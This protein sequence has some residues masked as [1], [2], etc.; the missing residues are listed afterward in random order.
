[1]RLQSITFKSFPPFKDVTLTLGVPEK[2]EQEGE[3]HILTGANGSGKTRLLS[4]IAAALGNPTELDRRQK[5]HKGCSIKATYG[6]MPGVWPGSPGYYSQWGRDGYGHGLARIPD[7]TTRTGFR[8]ILGIAWKGSAQ[9]KGAD[10]T[11][12]API[13]LK[14]IE[15]QLTF[16]RPEGEDGLICQSMTNLKMSAAMEMMSQPNVSGRAMTMT[17]NLEAAVSKVT[18]RAFSFSV[19]AHPKVSLQVSWGGVAMQFQQLPD[20]LRSIIGF[21]VACVAKVDAFA[22]EH[23]K[24]LDEPLFLL[25]DEPEGHLHPSWQRKILPAAQALFPKAMIFAATHSPFIISSVN[26]GWIYIFRSDDK[27]LVTVENPRPCSKGD[28]YLDVVED[29]LGVTEWYDPETEELL[30]DFRRMR[31]SVLG[32]HWDQEPAL[33]NKSHE[34][35][36][37]S[38]ALEDMMAREM[39]RWKGQGPAQKTAA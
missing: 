30:A 1:M 8:Y 37:R 2:P 14:S 27:G 12:L 34:I 22:P 15:E 31:D 18:G 29:I 39:R 24:P 28:S 13:K 11:A 5:G 9:V 23:P 6:S 19:T 3:V 16:D 26:K 33:R 10:V 36:S 21:L 38:P 35:G 7:K 17:R 20:G 25:L 32:G 4:L